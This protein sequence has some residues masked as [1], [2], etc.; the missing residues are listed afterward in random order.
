MLDES[1]PK[2]N[3]LRTQK[4]FSRVYEEGE[5]KKT[6]CFDFYI[7]KKEEPPPR[8]GIVA[9]ANIGKAVER[10]RVK[11]IIREGFRKNKKLFDDL[12]VIVI[13]K[14]PALRSK[15][16]ELSRDFL[17]FFERYLKREG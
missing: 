17:N 3:R 1:F 2:S 6:G 9:P 13:I 4:N 11:R 7:R 16:K 10:N 8:I 15:N 14:E 5:E 12:D